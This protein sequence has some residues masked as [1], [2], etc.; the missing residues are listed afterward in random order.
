VA[1]ADY[2]SFF[3]ICLFNAHRV[4]LAYGVFDETGNRQV[5]QSSADVD[6][7]DENEKDGMF[8]AMNVNGL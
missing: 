3:V 1:I 2:C 8:I 5:S 6:S 7:K 4:H